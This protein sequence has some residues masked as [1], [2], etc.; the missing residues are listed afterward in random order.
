MPNILHTTV[1]YNALMK[2]LVEIIKYSWSSNLDMDEHFKMLLSK[3]KKI[4]INDIN[5]YSFNNRGG[6][7]LY[8]DMSL[9]IFPPIE[10]LV[11]NDS[12][13][14]DLLKLRADN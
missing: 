3:V 14:E 2:I 6:K 5:R 1:G 10:G 9:L 4:E 8:L 7:Y 11:Q 12:R 13:K